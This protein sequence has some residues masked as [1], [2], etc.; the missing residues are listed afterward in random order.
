MGTGPRILSVYNRYLTRG[1]EDEIFD[2]ELALLRRHDQVVIP[3]T[4]SVSQPHS[5]RQLVRSGTDV[6]WSRQWHKRFLRLMHESKPDI[7]HIHNT[8]PVMSPSVCYAARKAGAAVV[9]TLHNYRL[10]CPNAIC[11]RNGHPCQDCL[12]RATPWPGILHACYRDSRL[13]SAGVA[14]ML[15]A[16]RILKTWERQVDAYI[17]LTQFERSVLIRGGL[18]AERVYVKPNFVYPDPG[19][20]ERDGDFCLFVGRLATHKGF[21]TLV[22]AWKHLSGIPLRVVGTP[23]SAT[24][25]RNVS[26]S[27]AVSSDIELL[28]MVSR[29]QVFD[30]MKGARLL[31]F[32]S[33]CYE[34]FGLTIVEAFA[35]GVPVIV[36]RLGA[37]ADLVED[38]LTGLHF[39]PGDSDDLA[40]KV[41]WAWTQREQMAI[42]GREARREYESKYNAE[43]NYEMLLDIYARARKHRD[44]H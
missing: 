20:R 1:G 23:T 30:L 28:G 39:T 19:P 15:T 43:V 2:S 21:P 41:K 5:L 4:E 11:F 25:E 36:S 12:G 35:C 27:T 31:V 18:P 38:G 14:A 29:D 37:M 44:R 9:H 40:K 22:R 26:A 10:V 42:M 3:V 32:P 24:E 8:F 17:A 7:V 33:E 13:E 34:T 16:H 6:V